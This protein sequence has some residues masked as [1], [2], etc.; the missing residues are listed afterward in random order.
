MNSLSNKNYHNF[1][2]DLLHLIK[3][4]KLQLDK[5]NINIIQT[6]NKFLIILK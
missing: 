3:Q 1:K 4:C 6:N 2:N 5:I